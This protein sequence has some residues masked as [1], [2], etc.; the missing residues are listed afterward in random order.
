M[1]LVEARTLTRKFGKQ[2][3]V[4]KDVD[5]DANA[6]EVLG[7]IGPNGGGKS[8]LLLLAAGLLRPTSGQITIDGIHAHELALQTKGAV[9]LITAVPGLYPLLS[10]WENLHYFGGLN[11]LT[12]AE[13][14]ERAT[15][16]VVDLGLADQMD[17]QVRSYSSGMQQKVSLTR[18]LLMQPKLLLLDEPTSNLDPVSTHNIH[19]VVRRQADQGVGVI[20]CTHDLH[21]AQS[22]CDRVAVMERTVVAVSVLEGERKAPQMGPLYQMYQTHVSQESTA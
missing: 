10:G 5:L 20:L 4:V 1:A 15:P 22:I 6:G 13:V 7:L 14:V 2:A 16:M 3:P 17:R 21:A 8:T 12:K 11:G 19:E 18:A 9:G